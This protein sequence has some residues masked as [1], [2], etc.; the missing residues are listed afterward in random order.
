M[1]KG[2]KKLALFQL[3]YVSSLVEP[4]QEVVATILNAAVRNN[5]RREITGMLLLAGGNVAQV[6]EG[7]KDAVQ[8]TFHYIEADSRHRGILVMTEQEIATRQFASWSVGITEITNANL[9]KL[10]VKAHVF[11]PT[12]DEIARRCT[13]GNALKLLNS[14]LSASRTR[15]GEL[16]S[17][18]QSMSPC[19]SNDTHPVSVY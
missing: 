11:N 18:S 16:A 5:K 6:L 8:E 14:F 1:C 3:S 7:E 10:P 13:E 4:Q 9:E 15:S 2:R 19:T 12:F 17:S